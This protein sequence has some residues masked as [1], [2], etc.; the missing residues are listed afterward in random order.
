[1]ARFVIP[2]S[3][4][5]ASSRSLRAFASAL[6]CSSFSNSA[7]ASCPVL[8][9]CNFLLSAAIS[10]GITTVSPGVNF[11]LPPFAALKSATE[12]PN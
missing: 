11:V 1:M 12:Q 9:D 10:P 3:F 8:S 6:I 5:I 7:R 2:N 4:K